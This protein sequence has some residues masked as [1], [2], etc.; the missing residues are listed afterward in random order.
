MQGNIIITNLILKILS[1]NKIRLTATERCRTPVT[2]S[3]KMK[4]LF[5]IAKPYNNSSNNKLI[6]EFPN[7]YRNQK[8]PRDISASQE[9]KKEVKEIALVESKQ[10][11]PDWRQKRNLIIMFGYITG[12]MSW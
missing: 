5:H 7:T 2:L 6:L 11:T 12:R 1:S 8:P 4:P 9:E 10:T 3:R